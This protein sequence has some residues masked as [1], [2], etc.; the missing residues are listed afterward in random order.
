M[1]AQ[2][3]GIADDI[4]TKRAL[5]DDLTARLRKAIDQFKAMGSR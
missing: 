2:H 5:S 4:K 3:P 1:A